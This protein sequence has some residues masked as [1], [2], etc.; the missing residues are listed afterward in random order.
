MAWYLLLVGRSG[1]R[2]HPQRLAVHHAYRQ[3]LTDSFASVNSPPVSLLGSRPS[4]KG[5]AAFTLSTPFESSSCNG[6]SLCC[7]RALIHARAD[8]TASAIA[9]SVEVASMEGSRSADCLGCPGTSGGYTSISATTPLS[10]SGRVVT[11][12]LNRS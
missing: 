4:T 6:S 7:P 2:C 10:G 5:H 9:S 3:I 8:R 12:T 11:T 1:Q